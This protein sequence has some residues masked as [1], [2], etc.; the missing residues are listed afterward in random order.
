MSPPHSVPV[1]S[2]LPPPGLM[3][4]LGAWALQ[5]AQSY[6][7][8][9]PWDLGC[10][11]QG[12]LPGGSQEICASCRCFQTQNTPRVRNGTGKRGE[13]ASGIYSNPD[14]RTLLAREP[15]NKP[16]L[17]SIL[18]VRKRRLKSVL[19]SLGS[20]HPRGAG[21]IL[22]RVWALVST[23]T[24]ESCYCVERERKKLTL[25]PHGE[26]HPGGGAS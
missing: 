24:T 26:N 14:L 22:I 9:V 8:R 12:G 19:R 3:G 15:S 18:Q 1:E 20:I 21:E 7:I 11:H 16:I 2:L 25:S 5:P 13:N 10:V 17:A 4:W 6:G 23:L